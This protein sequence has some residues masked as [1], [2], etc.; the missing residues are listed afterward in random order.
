M[1]GFALEIIDLATSTRGAT[2]GTSWASAERVENVRQKASAV[3]RSC[4]H[5]EI[6]KQ[7]WAQ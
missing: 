3:C 2:F 5:D 1:I 7:I 4:L 6:W